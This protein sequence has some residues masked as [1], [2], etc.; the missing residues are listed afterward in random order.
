MHWTLSLRSAIED[1]L[2]IQFQLRPLCSNIKRQGIIDEK[3]GEAR[4]KVAELIY[5]FSMLY[6]ALQKDKIFRED[7]SNKRSLLKIKLLLLWDC[8]KEWGG[9]NL[10]VPPGPFGP[11]GP[12]GFDGPTTMQSWKRSHFDSL[13]C[14]R[15]GTQSFHP[16]NSCQYR[17]H[18]N[19]SK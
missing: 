1:I 17:D 19:N 5:Y 14:K 10:V 9:V 15:L 16:A 18:L 6:Q 7:S 13:R 4:L 2:G 11:P 12:P 8:G 3:Q